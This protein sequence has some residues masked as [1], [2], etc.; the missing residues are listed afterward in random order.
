MKRKYRNGLLNLR[1]ESKI[2]QSEIAARL[3]ISKT[4]YQN[5]E[6]GVHD[7]PARHVR[8]LAEIFGCSASEVLGV[9]DPAG[10]RSLSPEEQ[11]LVDCYEG[12]DDTWRSLLLSFARAAAGS[13]GGEGQ[14]GATR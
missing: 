4:T 14:A 12:C 3:G 5:Y 8:Q 11:E 13:K 1:Y 2:T 7:V 9:P 10:V 6:W